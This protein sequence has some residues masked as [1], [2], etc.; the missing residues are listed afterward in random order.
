MACLAIVTRS[1]IKS[2]LRNLII[3]FQAFIASSPLSHSTPTQHTEYQSA[4]I[5]F[6][7]EAHIHYNIEYLNCINYNAFKTN[8]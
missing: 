7:C 4:V 5:L 6:N 1:E 8:H 2:I 3:E